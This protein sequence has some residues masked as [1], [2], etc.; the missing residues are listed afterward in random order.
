MTER[1]AQLGHTRP[2][3]HAGEILARSEH[4][5]KATATG[6]RTVMATE[7]STSGSSSGNA[8][9]SSS[10]N[11]AGV[12]QRIKQRINNELG[13]QKARAV[14]GLMS[15]A[16]AV[17]RMGEPLQGQPL[18]PAIRYVDSAAER[19][20]QAALYLRQHE[21][22]EVVDDV[23][24]VARRR[25]GVFIGVGLL[26]GAICGRLLKRSSRARSSRR[27]EVPASRMSEART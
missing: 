19:V 12:G 4:D 14:D 27:S 24:R 20:E 9:T 21:F 8:Q 22:N 7:Q 6:A 5:L 17:R 11:R 26:A 13:S 1:D 15:V 2:F 3:A 25:P 10:S 18:A 16:T 23:R